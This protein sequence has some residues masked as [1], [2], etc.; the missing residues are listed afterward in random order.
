M[1]RSLTERL[2]NTSRRP[3][4]LNR[5]RTIPAELGG[6][7]K[8]RRGSH[9]WD[10]LSLVGRSA[11]TE[12]SFGSWR[13]VQQP[14]FGRQ[15]QVRLA[16]M[17]CARALQAPYLDMCLLVQTGAGTVGFRKRPAEGTAVG[18]GERVCGD[19]TE[20]AT[21][22]NAQRGRLHSH[23]REAALLKHKQQGYLSPHVLPLASLGHQEGLQLGRLWGSFGTRGPVG[24][25]HAEVGLKPQM[26][27]RNSAVKES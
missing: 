10:A 24:G 22:R 21:A 14:G 7:L 4:T 15:D 17:V 18:C 1:E 3:E 5:V 16:E 23:R 9:T 25:A 12:R 8:E 19:E 20:E 26:S 11:G 27:S 13:R 2:L 6:K